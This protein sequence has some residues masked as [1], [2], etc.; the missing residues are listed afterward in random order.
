MRSRRFRL[1]GAFG[2]EN[3]IPTATHSTMGNQ[4]RGAVLP[5][6]DVE[7]RRNAPMP[8]LP[9]AHGAHPNLAKVLGVSRIS[10]LPMRR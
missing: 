6:S 3:D 9:R 7:W 2:A 1:P 8:A 4:N 5:S 10:Q